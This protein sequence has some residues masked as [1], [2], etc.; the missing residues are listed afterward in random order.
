MIKE[1]RGFEEQ[2]AAL[3]NGTLERYV[4]LQEVVVECE[5]NMQKSAAEIDDNTKNAFNFAGMSTLL[6]DDQEAE[7]EAR[8]WRTEEQK[9]TK[10]KNTKLQ[11]IYDVL[12]QARDIAIAEMKELSAEN[13]EL[14]SMATKEKV[15]ELKQRNL[16][17]DNVSSELAR[18]IMKAEG[19][20][21][22]LEQIAA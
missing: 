12:A 17:K 16:I 5:A 2:Y 10:E 9:N 15:A 13:V 11:T 20:D 19:E 4:N 6:G 7:S 8:K 1:G 18:I 3:E 22:E 14:E 21:N